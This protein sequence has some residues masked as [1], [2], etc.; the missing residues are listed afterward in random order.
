MNLTMLTFIKKIL[1]K[2]LLN[3][4]W[5][6]A[7]WIVRKWLFQEG[8]EVLNDAFTIYALKFQGGDKAKNRMILLANIL[9]GVKDGEIR[10]RSSELFRMKMEISQLI[11]KLYY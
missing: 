10:S 9:N 6:L 5:S 11:R 1:A 7:H 2:W 3:R 8:L 4:R